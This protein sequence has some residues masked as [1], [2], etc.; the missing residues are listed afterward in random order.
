MINP[1]LSARLRDSTPFA[2]WTEVAWLFFVASIVGHFSRLSEDPVMIAW[3]VAAGTG[4]L[5]GIFGICKRGYWL[6]LAMLAS[7]ILVISSALYWQGVIEAVLSQEQQKTIGIV[8]SRIWKIIQL[9]LPNGINSGTSH[10]VIATYYRELFMPT[11]QVLTLVFVGALS[12][13]DKKRGDS[14]R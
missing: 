4:V 2:W 1:A 7:A 11:V 9:G 8:L 12:A 6:G 13:L 3:W 10:W 5:A 14:K